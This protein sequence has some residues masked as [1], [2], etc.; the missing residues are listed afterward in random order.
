MMVHPRWCWFALL[1]ALTLVTE[2]ARAQEVI[3]IEQMGFGFST[4]KLRV[5]SCAPTYPPFV[6]MGWDGKLSGFE[7]F[8]TCFGL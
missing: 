4:S 8:P 7:V 5:G 2:S 1:V 3:V 6:M